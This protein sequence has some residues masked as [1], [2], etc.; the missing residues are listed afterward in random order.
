MNLREFSSRDQLFAAGLV[1]PI[2]LDD[3]KREVAHTREVLEL[4]HLQ[5]IYLVPVEAMV[6]VESEHI[7][8][9]G[10]DLF[11]FDLRDV[12]AQAEKVQEIQ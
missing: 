11:A 4:R 1:L 12:K 2:Y 6:L 5:K 10:A 9:A 7:I 8:L 3:N